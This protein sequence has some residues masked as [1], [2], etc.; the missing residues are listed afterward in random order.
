MLR[1]ASSDEPAIGQH[2]IRFEQVVDRQTEAASQVANASAQGD[3]T[4]AGGRDTAAWRGESEGM[5]R[6]VHITQRR[7]PFNPNC[8]GIGIDANT[9]HQREIDDKSIIDETETGTAVAATANRDS[10]V[11]LASEIDGRDDVGDVDA[12]CDD[13]RSLVDH[14]VVDLAYLIVVG[15][16]WGDDRTAHRRCKCFDRLVG[17]CLGWTCHDCSHV[18]DSS[19]F[20]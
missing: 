15:V 11:V 8:A 1:R 12:A 19:C 14:G 18:R 4:D 6:M 16:G 10:H 3:A 7:S 17:D 2:D 5:R 13:R 9:L 20:V